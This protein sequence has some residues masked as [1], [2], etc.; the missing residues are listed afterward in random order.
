MTKSMTKDYPFNVINY[1]SDA[2]DLEIT[3]NYIALNEMGIDSVNLVAKYE[4]FKKMAEKM[5]LTIEPMP[6]SHKLYKKIADEVKEDTKTRLS[7]DKF[8]PIIEV[9][10]LPKVDPKD[11][12]FYISIVR[13]TP[14]LFDVAKHY[15]RAK[16]S[17]CLITFAGLHQ[18]SKKISSEAMKSISKFFKRKA[19]KVQRI[20]IAIDT[21]DNRGINKDNIEGFRADLMPFS[22]R[23]VTLYKSSFYINDMELTEG[24]SM[25]KINFYDKY[26][27]Q[28]DKQKKEKIPSSLK[29]WKRLEVT[30][31]FDVTNK[32]NKGFISYVESMAFLDD[33]YEL[34]AVAEKTGIKSYETD[35]LI[36]QINSFI[37]NR[38][39]NNH[40]SREQ[41][42]S[43]D[44]LERFKSSDF[45]RY[46]L[47]I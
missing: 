27:K 46:V 29:T 41:F 44:A 28:L 3:S 11:K 15:H 40:E 9:I 31:M 1:P 45:R 4:V 18:P 23:G 34:H 36:M 22:K 39:M 8:T 20:D 38:F 37:D 17:F 5:G 21:E 7:V 12:D 42:N 13:N 14:T 35:Y 24:S 30:L 25:S 47:A 16:D 32:Q 19:F 2:H 43:V 26:K 6:K 10:K 33:I